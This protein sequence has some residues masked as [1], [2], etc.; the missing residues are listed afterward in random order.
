MEPDHTLPAAFP[1]PMPMHLALALTKARC[2]FEQIRRS[3]TAKVQ[4][5]N[6]QTGKRYEYEYHFATFADMQAATV[7]AL[8]DEGIGV[9]PEIRGNQ[10]H[11][12]LTLPEKGEVHDSGGVTI[13]KYTT[14]QEQGS[15]LSYALKYA[16][17]SAL[18]L[19]HDDD[20]GRAAEEGQQQ[21]NAQSARQ[22]PQRPATA[23]P[24]LAPSDGLITEELY[25]RVVQPQ[26]KQAG[27]TGKDLIAAFNVERIGLLRED[28]LPDIAEWIEKN[29]PGEPS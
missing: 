3:E 22:A 14:P 24:K 9:I 18:M 19:T 28:Q 27:L 29:N 15:A 12:I 16:Y 26:L 7:Q 25:A 1:A 21:R 5:T 8:A 4:G 2:K 23:A 20:D 10:V 11:M 17:R 13:G 6:R